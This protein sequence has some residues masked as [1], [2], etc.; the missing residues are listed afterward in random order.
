MTLNDIGRV[1]VYVSRFCS[2]WLQSEQRV[3]YT[4]HSIK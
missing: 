4:L 3:A 1:N 2:Q